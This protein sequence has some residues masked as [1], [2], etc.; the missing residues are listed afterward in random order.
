MSNV[1]L[2]S[3]GGVATA[4]ST[5]SP[6]YPVTAVNDGDRIGAAWAHG[7]GWNDATPGVYP[8]WVQ[9]TFAGSKTIDRVIVYTQQDDTPVEPG[10]TLT[11][12]QWGIVDFSVQGWDGAAWVALGSVTGN[13]LV[14]RTVAFA[15]YATDRIRVVVTKAS[16]NPKYP[17]SRIIEIE[18]WEPDGTVVTPP[19]VVPPPVVVPPATSPNAA[20]IAAI[21][22]KIAELQALVNQLV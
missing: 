16:P 8:D 18:A 14:K 9:I 4:S 21:N 22:A 3:N 11:F 13:N 5:Y 2:A 7:G 10:D 12:T 17:Y 15:A 20:T 19:P 6:D 1:A